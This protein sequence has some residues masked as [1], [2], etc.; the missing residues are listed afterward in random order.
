MNVPLRMLIATVLLVLTVGTGISTSRHGK[1]Y[2][3]ILFIFHKLLSGALT[4]YTLLFIIGLLRMSQVEIWLL[5]VLLVGGLSTVA[6][7]VSGVLMSTERISLDQASTIHSVAAVL[8]IV[9]VGI[10]LLL[11]IWRTIGNPEW[12]GMSAPQNPRSIV[13]KDWIM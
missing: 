13:E 7:F 12:S 11:M 2:P 10:F 6:L 1:P 4:L 3:D 8:M 9:T 5:L